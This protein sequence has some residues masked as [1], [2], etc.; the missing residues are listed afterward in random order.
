MITLATIL[1]QAGAAPQPAGG[2]GIFWI[3]IIALFAI[4]YFF[5]IR[6]QRK[7]QKEIENF[8][9]ALHVGQE[10]ITAGGIHGTIRQIDEASNVIVLEIAKDVKIRIDKTCIYADSSSVAAQ[11]GEVK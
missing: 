5:M 11:Q 9:K 8:R 6:P 3:M 10:V 2:G 7:K 4:M 1:L